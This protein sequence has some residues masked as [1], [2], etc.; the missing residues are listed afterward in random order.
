MS[1]ETGR[2][3]VTNKGSKNKR[4]LSLPLGLRDKKKKRM[5]SLLKGRH[6]RGGDTVNKSLLGP[7]ISERR[8]QRIQTQ[9]RENAE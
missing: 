6:G 2:V 8:A 9:R 5:N 4:E 3:K 1:R 7:G